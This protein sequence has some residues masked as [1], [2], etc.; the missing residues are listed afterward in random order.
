MTGI[1]PAA[2]T[3]TVR[4]ASRSL[5]RWG[6]AGLIA[7]IVAV[8]TWLVAGAWQGPGYSLV[9]DDISDMGALTAPHAWAFLIPQ[10]LAGAG[11]IAFVLF[12]L[13]PALTHAGRAGRSGPWLA[14]L[15]GIQDV[16]DAAFRLDCRAADGCGQAQAAVS[17]HAQAHN[18]IGF[19]CVL[20]LI[21]TPFVLARRFRRLPEWRRFALPS[22]L[23]GV[24]F[25]AGLLAVLAPQ[26]A[27]YQGLVQRAIALGGAVW[28][29]AVAA[30][31]VR[32]G[33]AEADG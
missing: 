25:V 7:E 29:I 9:H 27:S 12:G 4:P 10:A 26:T 11:T 2:R 17:W 30:H 6:M 19:A 5:A 14:A 18:A 20:L 28:G 3:V 13:R 21:V 8:C 15:S 1:R 16:T 33:R 23:L 31:L 32:L 24:V 22:V